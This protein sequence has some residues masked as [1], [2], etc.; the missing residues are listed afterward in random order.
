MNFGTYGLGKRARDLGLFKDICLR[1]L[2]SGLSPSPP[3]HHSGL[4]TLSMTPAL[5]S[6]HVIVPADM[7]IPVMET[8]TIAVKRQHNDRSR[9]FSVPTEIIGY[10]LFELQDVKCHSWDS[11]DV[12]LC[13]I[14]PNP[15]WKIILLIRFRLRKL[16]LRLISSGPT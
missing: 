2:V 10:V 14:T 15:G 6:H 3:L 9:L 12:H 1:K 5:S 11:C 13:N 8:Q 16:Q 4:L 7:H